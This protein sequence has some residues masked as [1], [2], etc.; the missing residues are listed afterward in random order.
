MISALSLGKL[1]AVSALRETSVVFSVLLG[2]IL[3]GETLTRR[4][5]AAC[6][7]VAVGAACIAY[8][9]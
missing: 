3:L 6:T 1:G 9:A 8:E 5:F 7:V 2:R 4:R